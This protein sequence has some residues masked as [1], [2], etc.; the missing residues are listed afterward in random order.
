MER[1]EAHLH[2]TRR[3]VA[4]TYV[5]ILRRDERAGPTLSHRC[6]AFAGTRAMRASTAS[7]A[8]ATAAEGESVV[9]TKKP[10]LH[11][12]HD[13]TCSSADRRQLHD[14]RPRDTGLDFT[15]HDVPLAP[16]SVSGCHEPKAMGTFI[17]LVGNL[18]VSLRFDGRETLT[19]FRTAPGRAR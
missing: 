18:V 19:H 12:R 10:R 8:K 11:E 7:V 1:R 6:V 13:N 4:A 5:M 15:L 17:L 16:R 9:R 2:D 14:R 3:P